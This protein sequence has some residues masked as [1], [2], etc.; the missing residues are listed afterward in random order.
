MIN[1]NLNLWVGLS[2]IISVISITIIL[3]MIYDCKQ[4][5]RIS[6]ISVCDQPVCTV[7]MAMFLTACGM[8]K[9]LYMYKN[10]LI[11]ILIIQLIMFG[12]MYI[13]LYQYIHVLL[14]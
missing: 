8:E 1:H 11:L 2:N 10:L 3:I 4:A 14:V 13:N 9:I 5:R 6:M 12:L 7:Y